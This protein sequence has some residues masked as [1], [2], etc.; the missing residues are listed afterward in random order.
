MDGRGTKFTYQLSNGHVQKLMSE[1]VPRAAFLLH[2]SLQTRTSDSLASESVR[3]LLSRVLLGPIFGHT[4]G[5]LHQLGDAF[6]AFVLADTIV[7]VAFRWR[8]NETRIQKTM[9]FEDVPRL[10]YEIFE[11][12]YFTLKKHARL[13]KKKSEKPHVFEISWIIFVNVR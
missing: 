2:H 3:V 13:D 1:T 4:G 5:R 8:P 12:K 7:I 10:M 11:L 6:V 9:F